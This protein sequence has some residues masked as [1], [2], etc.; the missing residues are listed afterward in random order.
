[1]YNIN[2]K[3]FTIIFIIGAVLTFGLN[4]SFIFSVMYMI[5]SLF[6]T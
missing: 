5:K 1:M 2:Y 4:I 3:K 6:F